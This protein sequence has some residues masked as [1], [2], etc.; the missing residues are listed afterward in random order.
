MWHMLQSDLAVAGLRLLHRCP[1]EARGCAQLTE[2]RVFGH[3]WT[4][5]VVV[6]FELEGSSERSLSL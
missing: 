6:Q 4:W 5:L 3:R 2:G 1:R